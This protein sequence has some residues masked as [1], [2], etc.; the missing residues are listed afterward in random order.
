K[1]V[2]ASCF[3]QG[4]YSSTETTGSQW[5]IP[6]DFPER[7]ATVPMGFLLPGISFAIVDDD[8]APVG[9]GGRGELLIRSMY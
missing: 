9:P 6:P 8:G 4:S 3:I 7:G 2:S 5:F 1:A